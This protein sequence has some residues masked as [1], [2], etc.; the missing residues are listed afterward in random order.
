MSQLQ[1]LIFDVDG[2]LADTERDGHRLAFNDAFAAAGLDWQWNEALYGKLL[3]VAGGKERIRF[4]ISMF[5]PQFELPADGDQ[6]IEDLHQ[7][8]SAHYRR[9]LA[10]GTIPLRPGVRR[11][12]QEARQQEI[13]LAIATT[14]TFPNATALLKT[15]LAADSPDWFEVI[16]AGDIVPDKKPAPDIYR[17]VLQQLGLNPNEALA[18]EDTQHGLQAATQAGLQTVVTVNDYTYQQNFQGAALVISHLGEPSQPFEVLAGDA[19]DATYFDLAL[20]RSLQRRG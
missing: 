15:A 10:E 12:L 11:V 9:R 19:G 6:W 8:K 3:A 2:T 13:W 4:Y 1:A 16:A 14:S 5:Q 7:A 18:I 17:Y 20:G